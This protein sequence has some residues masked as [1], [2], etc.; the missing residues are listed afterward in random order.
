M[1]KY[2][3]AFFL[4]FGIVSLS[5]QKIYYVKQGGSGVKNG[6]S[7][8]NASDEI[9]EMINIASSGDEI[10]V[11][12]GIY[13]PTRRADDLTTIPRVP[14]QDFAFVLKKDVKIYGGFK[15]NEDTTEFYRRNV[16]T[17]P[18]I[19]SGLLREYMV[20]GSFIFPEVRAYH[21]VVSSGD[22]GSAV[23]NG[24]TIEKGN[25]NAGGG[26]TVNNQMIYKYQGGGIY[27]INSSPDLKY[28]KIISNYSEGDGGG[29]YIDNSYSFITNTIISN[30]SVGGNTAK[31]GGIYC[32]SGK[33][34]LTNVELRNNISSQGGGLYIWTSN[35]VLTNVTIAGNTA[36]SGGSGI[37][38]DN[39]VSRTVKVRNSI[40]YGNTGSANTYG[41]NVVN[42]EYSLINGLTTVGT[43]NNLAGTTNPIFQTNSYKIQTNSPCA[44]VGN[45]SYF[46][47]GQ[48][49]DLSGI[50]TELQGVP[51]IGDKM[52]VLGGGIV[53]FYDKVIDLGA[54]QVTFEMYNPIINFP[55]SY[56]PDIN[57]GNELEA[58]NKIELNIFPNPVNFNH[59][60]NIS[61]GK[62]DKPVDVSMYS[63]DGKLIFH[64]TYERNN[65]ELNVP[66]LSSGMYMINI[67]TQEG[68]S[69]TKKI[70][71][72]K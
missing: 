23:L 14:S 64:K 66:D 21:V 70:V 16:N 24:F 1:K 27:L 34:T 56:N 72:N 41:I 63:L 48:I 37:Y 30:N 71:V 18:T 53:V 52:T 61:L 58:E 5:A 26:I 49:P 68:E 39:P 28:L 9:Q 12:E 38:C 33:L 55:K 51:R 65:F 36:T 11:A 15:G 35:N 69:F 7:W 2:L 8:Q 60:I 62:Y 43:N 57:F 13:R 46:N 3:I 32:Q 29:I 25:A 45:L 44:K 54:Y 6:S 4:C 42:C 10:W 31:G 50:T 17:N 40:I 47:S 20:I 19:L 59:P 22:V 67:Q